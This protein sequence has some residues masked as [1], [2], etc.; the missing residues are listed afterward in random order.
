MQTS[1]AESSMSIS[2]RLR[3]WQY[4]SLQAVNTLSFS[5]PAWAPT[6]QIEC[7]LKQSYSWQM[8]I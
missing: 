4:G 8:N 7:D 5:L 1:V 3:E 6:P 2:G